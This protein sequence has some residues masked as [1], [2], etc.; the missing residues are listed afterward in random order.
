MP[1]IR[2]AIIAFILLLAGCTHMYT[3]DFRVA[4]A[5]TLTSEGVRNIFTGFKGLLK[6]KGM[7]EVTQAGNKNPDYAAFELGSGKSGILRQP[8]EEYLQLSYTPEN[9]FVISIVRVIDHPVDFSAQYIADFKS[10]T[11]QLIHEATSK[12]VQLQPIETRRP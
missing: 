12:H 5:E 1:T 4:P 2:V 3:H 10:Q 9:G 11:E 8:F 6:S 7:H